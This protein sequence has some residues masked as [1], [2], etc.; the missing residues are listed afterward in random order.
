MQKVKGVPYL[1]IRNGVYYFRRAIPPAYRERLGKREHLVSL[2]TG[3]RAEAMAAYAKVLAQT[4]AQLASPP[5]RAADPRNAPRSAEFSRNALEDAARQWVAYRVDA[6]D[7][8]VAD[9]AADVGWGGDPEHSPDD[10]TLVHTAHRLSPEE[11][12]LRNTF[13]LDTH[14]LAQH[15]I[16]RAGGNPADFAN[17]SK[18][19]RA[20]LK[21]AAQAQ[22]EK[23]HRL[24]ALARGKQV[25][26]YNADLFAEE[27]MAS[28]SGGSKRTL[29][30]VRD[31]FIARQRGRVAEKTVLDNQAKLKLMLSVLG[32][33]RRIDQVEREDVRK[34]RGVLERLPPRFRQRYPHCTPEQAGDMAKDDGISPISKKTVNTYLDLMSSFFDFAEVEEYVAK[35]PATKLQLPINEED[36]LPVRTFTSEELNLIFEAP[37]FTGCVD[38]DSNYSKPGPNRPKRHRY[39]VPLIALFS[40]MRLS[41]IC[42]L[43]HANMV[44]E[45]GV[46]CFSVAALPWQKSKTANSRR[47]VPAHPTLIELGFREYVDRQAPDGSLFPSLPLGKNGAPGDPMSKWFGRLL[48]GLGMDDPGYRFHSFRHTWRTALRNAQVSEELV[49]RLG[50]WKQGGLHAHYGDNARAATLYQAIEKVEYE[51]LDLSRVS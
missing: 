1:Y 29:G 33:D 20:A 47:L 5:A 9:N 41:E 17:S 25:T 42:E 46:L 27:L 24:K 3:R 18:E 32:M 23:D 44:E 43:Q 4:Q 14:W 34:L 30:Q 50:G 39:W 10:A 49:C 40:G 2:G 31:E 28:S 15:L 48:D 7:P 13:A 16:E 36:S 19:Y 38:D 8:G 6:D 26:P 37:V 12:G 21:V 45:D 11:G 35:N 22:R 51:G